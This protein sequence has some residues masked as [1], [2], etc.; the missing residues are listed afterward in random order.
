[1]KQICTT[2]Q[3]AAVVK[4]LDNYFTAWMFSADDNRVYV[5]DATKDEIE[6][7]REY[8]AA[9][10]RGIESQFPAIARLEDERV[11]LLGVIKRLAANY[12]PCDKCSG[13]GVIL[14]TDDACHG[15]GGTGRQ[16]QSRGEILDLEQAA[17]AILQTQN[18]ANKESQKESAI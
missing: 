12:E 3:S 17:N 5:E 9:F 7:M 18:P 6:E 16:I 4:E 2:S 13:E 10:Y 1:M 11:E 8:A 15:C 14:G